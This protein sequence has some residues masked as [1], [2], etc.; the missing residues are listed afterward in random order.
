MDAT[1]SG[2]WKIVLP[3]A[4]LVTLKT[5]ELS[6]EERGELLTGAGPRAVPF[7]LM[8]TTRSSYTSVVCMHVHMH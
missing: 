7:V 8:R 4:R 1:G 5:R 2:T 6:L 3:L